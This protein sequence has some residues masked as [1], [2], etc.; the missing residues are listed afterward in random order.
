MTTLN[1][2]V[3]EYEKITDNNRNSS[4]TAFYNLGDHINCTIKI[5]GTYSRLFSLSYGD[6]LSLDCLISYSQDYPFSPPNWSLTRIVVSDHTQHIDV[7][8]YYKNIVENH[9][10]QY[11]YDW[12]PSINLGTDML[13]FIQKIN[14]FEYIFDNVYN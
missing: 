1:R 14:H 3:K 5:A 6:M 9:N 2:I 8:E 10:L 12:S 7:K 13:D 4:L 11:T